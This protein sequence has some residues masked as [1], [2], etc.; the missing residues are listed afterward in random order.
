[1]DIKGYKYF[2]ITERFA[3]AILAGTETL[4]LSDETKHLPIGIMSDE[5]GYL[6]ELKPPGWPGERGPH[7]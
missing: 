5:N 7:T 1:M 3:K 4:N 6:L 2:P